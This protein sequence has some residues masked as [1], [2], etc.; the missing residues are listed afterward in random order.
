MVTLSPVQFVD[1]FEALLRE[2]PSLKTATRLLDLLRPNY[3]WICYNR[4]DIG[5]LICNRHVSSDIYKLIQY[6]KENSDNDVVK[7][8]KV[9]F[10]AILAN[11][12]TVKNFAEQLTQ[13]QIPTAVARDLARLQSV[14]M[15]SQVSKKK[16][17]TPSLH[18]M[19]IVSINSNSCH[20]GEIS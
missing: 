8:V 9:D 20:I 19:E 5:E 2:H 6:Y 7:S 16:R 11:V 12:V 13:T 10:Y 17:C 15:E 1:Q 14:Y 4:R 18:R 3:N